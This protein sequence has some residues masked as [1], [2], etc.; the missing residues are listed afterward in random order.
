MLEKIKKEVVS[1]IKDPAG[2]GLRAAWYVVCLGV[3]IWTLLYALAFVK[4]LLTT[5]WNVLGF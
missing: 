2:Y 5:A 4:Y 3:G 1:A